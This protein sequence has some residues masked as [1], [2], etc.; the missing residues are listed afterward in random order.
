VSNATG[1]M[2]QVL[3]EHRICGLEGE[4]MARVT[5]VIDSHVVGVEKPDPRIFSFAFEALE[6]V[7]DRC[8][9][10][11]DSVHFDV[12]GARNAGIRPFHLDPFSLCGSGGHEHIGALADF[13]AELE[14]ILA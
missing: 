12:Q 2:E 8:V 9:Y 3:L 7:P 1:R 5:A 11:G 4:A 13:A 10:I 6:T 14:R